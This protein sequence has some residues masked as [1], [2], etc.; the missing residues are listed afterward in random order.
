MANA[1]PWLE[2]WRLTRSRR[3]PDRS[4]AGWL[5]GWP[6]LD[7]LASMALR[8]WY[9]PLSRLWA[10]AEISGGCVD[11]F[12]EAVPLHPL[13]SPRRGLEETLAEFEEARITAA[14]IDRAWH[15]GFFRSEGPDGVP[16][17]DAALAALEAS[18]FNARHRLNMMR[19]GFRGLLKTHPARVGFA[20][21]EPS[22][23]ADCYERALAD[24]RPAF[25]APD[26]MPPVRISR[27]IA[28][29]QG[30]DYWLSFRSPSRRLGDHVFARVHEPAGVVDPPTVIFGH[31]VCIE[32]DHWRRL[33]DE[34]AGL[35][36]R[37][38]RVIRPEAPWHGRRRPRGFYGGERMI[39]AF[40]LGNL[41][42][43]TGAVREWAVLADWARQTSD[44]PLAFAGSSLGALT[45]QLAADRSNAWPSHLRPDALFLITH[46]WQFSHALEEGE[47]MRILGGEDTVKA[48][49]WQPETV[50]RYLALLAPGAAPPIPPDRIVSVLGRQDRVTPFASGAEL[51]KSWKVPPE[52]CFF[53]DRGHFSIPVTLMRNH[54]PLDRFAEVLR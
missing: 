38:I 33:I 30:R 40:P 49:G 44:G 51:V 54:A 43:V 45:A 39:A 48:K 26:P 4:A 9:F 31:G 25:A 35:V 3:E 18:R 41:D 7:P 5:F 22:D 12:F 8:R 37:G 6:W 53:W 19:R 23:V 1:D 29:R 27:S 10:A 24:P 14:A 16:P 32:F 52:N 50:G 20:I 2:H 11:S 28:T 15:N 34:T 46:C 21:P 17:S 42:L 36:E 47:L 13:R